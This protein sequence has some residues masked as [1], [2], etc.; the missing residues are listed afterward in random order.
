MES[1]DKLFKIGLLL[2]GLGFLTAYAYYRNPSGVTPNLS[3]G[4]SRYVLNV[5]NLGNGHIVYLVDT[6]EG[7]VFYAERTGANYDEPLAWKVS[8]P[9]PKR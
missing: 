9:Q 6:Q 4:N 5:G 2:L 7:T 8:Q 3:A 1:V